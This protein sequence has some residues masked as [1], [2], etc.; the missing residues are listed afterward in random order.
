MNNVGSIDRALRILIGLFVISLA[1][2]GPR[3]VWG[4]VGVIPLATALVGWCPLYS[5]LGI[6]TCRAKGTAGSG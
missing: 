4:W 3:T 2:W 1:F 6:R 5:V